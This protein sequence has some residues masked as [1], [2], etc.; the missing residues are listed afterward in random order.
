MTVIR[1]A[2]IV[3]AY[4][5]GDELFRC[6][7]AV[8]ASGYAALRLIVI[9]NAS[10][11]GACDRLRALGSADVHVVEM[12]RNVGFAG[13]V[14]AGVAWLRDHGYLVDDDVVVLVNQDCIVQ[15]GAVAALVTR[16]LS[17]PRIGV[18]G[19]RILAPDERTLQHAG[20]LI[21]EN[22]LTEHLGRGLADCA[23]FWTLRDVEYVT[24]ALCAFRASTWAMLGPFD[25]R[26]QP[27]YFEE[28]DFCLRARRAGLR[29]V[30]EPACV[31]IHAEAASSGGTSSRLF[32]RRYHRNRIRFLAHHCLRR[33]SVMRTL[34]AELRWLVAQRRVG[35]VWPVLRAYAGLALDLTIGRRRS[36]GIAR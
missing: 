22:G 36:G 9:D 6:V 4:D 30:Y 21:R 31:A 20:G 33:G 12:S 2:A 25:E 34:G 14:N 10:V 26:Y 1:V 29:V 28:V 13:G 35:D 17:D 18:V 23:L 19:A 32:L 3:V 11:D 27:V 16:L 24:G 8:R 7:D 5:G 15:Q